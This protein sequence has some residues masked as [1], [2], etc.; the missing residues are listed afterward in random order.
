MPKEKITRTA[1]DPTP[2]AVDVDMPDYE[3]DPYFIKKH[4]QAVEF[5]KT[6]GL[7]EYLEEKEALRKK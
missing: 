5:V 1:L 6:S 7:I 2:E 3:N 4:E